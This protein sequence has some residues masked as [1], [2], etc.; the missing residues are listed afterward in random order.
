MRSA[1]KLREMCRKNGGYFI[2]M[3]QHIGALEYLLS[4]EYVETFKVF[5]SDA[6]QTSIAKLKKVIEE[7]LHC[8]GMS[9]IIY[10]TDLM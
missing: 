2:K 9:Y 7:E 10:V 4:S 1:Q 3:G 6:P 5:H 8:P